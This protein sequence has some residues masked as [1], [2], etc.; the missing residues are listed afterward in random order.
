MSAEAM[1]GFWQSTEGN[2]ALREQVSM[3]AALPPD[4]PDE[5]FSP[6]SRLAGEAGFDCTTQDLRSASQVTRFWS[7]IDQRS[8]LAREMMRADGLEPPKAIE[9]IHSVAQKTGCLCSVDDFDVLSRALV[10][11]QIDNRD[12]SDE[13]LDKVAGGTTTTYTSYYYYNSYYSQRTRSY[14]S[15][16]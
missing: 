16:Y 3:L 2:V 5:A 12:L 6:L 10:G 1:V 9:L 14:S 15:Y 13:D 8:D 4:S 11:S 7:L